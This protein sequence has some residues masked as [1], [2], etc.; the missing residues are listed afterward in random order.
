MNSMTDV[1]RNSGEL[2]RS[3]EYDLTFYWSGED[4]PVSRRYELAFAFDEIASTI[5]GLPADFFRKVGPDL[6]SERDRVVVLSRQDKVIGFSVSRRLMV[7]DQPVLFRRYSC[8]YA[9]DR[10]YGLYS[11]LTAPVLEH[12][13]AQK[14]G[15][16][17]LAWRTRN[18]VVWFKNAAMCRRVA[19]DL[20]DGRADSELTEL[21]LAVCRAVYP[22]AE[23]DP[24][25][26]TV[27]S[28]YP[29][30]TGYQVQPRHP[31]PELDAI[32]MAHP[33]MESRHN[34]LF[35]IGEI[36]SAPTR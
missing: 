24:V 27:N 14:P 22:K 4:V 33:G 11:A 6:F 15:T 26:L 20:R 1:L 13:I 30:N 16:L 9:A 18:P 19:P 17:F 31:L 29:G 35:G 3:G 10:G 32:F 23:V 7:G 8:M 2:R 21:A 25:T 28:V 36:K 12:E 34:A 5:W